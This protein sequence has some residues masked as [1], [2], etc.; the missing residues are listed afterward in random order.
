MRKIFPF[1]GLV[2]MLTKYCIFIS[3]DK[4]KEQVIA[5]L[6]KIEEIRIE[7]TYRNLAL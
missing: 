6:K 4:K 7:D 5:D 2:T 1:L 3:G